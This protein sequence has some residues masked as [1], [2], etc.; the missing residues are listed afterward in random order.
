MVQGI[1]LSSSQL[2]GRSLTI[3]LFSLLVGGLLGTWYFAKEVLNVR[4]RRQL[5]VNAFAYLV[6]VLSLGGWFARFGWWEPGWGVVAATVFGL[7]VLILKIPP[8]PPKETT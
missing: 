7:L 4:I 8:L 3:G 6:W 2:V 1:L 5:G